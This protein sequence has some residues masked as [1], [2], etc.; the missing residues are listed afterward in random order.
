MAGLLTTHILD[1]SK[2]FPAVGVVIELFKRCNDNNVIVTKNRTN[3]DGRTD[4][5]I[6]SKE[7]FEIGEYEL[8]FH[9]GDYF[10]DTYPTTNPTVFFNIIPVRFLII[11]D[12]HYHVPL[13][14]SPFG[15]STYRG[16]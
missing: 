3:S 15:Y 2:G 4:N 1:T 11:E 13:L 9:V 10:K 14:L 16:S 6:L 12:R 5:P 8:N 7:D